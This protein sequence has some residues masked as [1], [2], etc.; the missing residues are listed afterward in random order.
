MSTI[1][2][3]L[4]DFASLETLATQPTVLSALDARAKILA[5]LA[6][7]LTVVSFDRYAVAALLP[8]A[9]FPMLL[10][11]LG[12]IPW[13]TIGR[14]VLLASP[15]AVMMG[16]FNPLFDQ[17]VIVTVAGRGMQRWLAF[18]GFHPD[19][20]CLDGFH[21]ADSG[22]KHRFSPPLRRLVRP[23]SASGVYHPVAAAA[24][25]RRGAGG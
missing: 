3:A 15:F 5:T 25:L 10:A 6:F 14:S 21:R 23:G 16:V 24:S 7:I 19:S 20:L 17:Q 18:I 11:A 1:G 2:T 4:R 12:N 22:W 8:L 13:R 9:V